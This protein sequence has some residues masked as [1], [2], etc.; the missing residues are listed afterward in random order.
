MNMRKDYEHCGLWK[1]VEEDKE[2]HGK[3]GEWLPPATT[4]S[5]LRPFF[6]DNLGKPAP[7]R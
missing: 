4:T 5:V 1:D 6:Q 7:E 2:V 3:D